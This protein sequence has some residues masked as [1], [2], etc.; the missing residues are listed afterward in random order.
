MNDIDL[1]KRLHEKLL[2]N[3]SETEDFHLDKLVQTTVRLQVEDHPIK[4]YISNL[5]FQRNKRGQ[6]FRK[7]CFLA[8]LLDGC[9]TQMT[10]EFLF[11]YDI[12]SELLEN[13]E[14]LHSKTISWGEF[15]TFMAEL[16]KNKII[17]VKIEPAFQNK[18]RV[19]Q[20]KE[21]KLIAKEK[22]WLAGRYEL[23]EEDVANYINKLNQEYCDK[24]V[25]K[26]YGGQDN[27]FKLVNN[28]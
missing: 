28:D 7:L 3:L 17:K 11:S 27:L 24:I 12:C 18:S 21:G 15:C 5:Y 23:I 25:A 8:S 16:K 1:E 13:N 22:G 14:N 10:T 6:P 2:N 9:V 20:N 4:Q 19:F 26:E